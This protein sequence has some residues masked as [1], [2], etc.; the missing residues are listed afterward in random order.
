MNKDIFNELKE[1]NK[2]YYDM[3]AYCCNDMILNNSLMGELNQLGIEFDVYCGED[4]D[5]NGEYIDIFQFYLISSN[6]ASRLADLTNELVYYN[7]SL[8]LYFLAV[9]H[10]G[11]SWDYVPSNWKDEL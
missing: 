8:D 9:T 2:T 7:N 3:I 1:E 10:Y 11:T 5:E 4:M 6:D